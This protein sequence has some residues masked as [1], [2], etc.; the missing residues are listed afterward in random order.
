MIWMEFGIRIPTIR[1]LYIEKLEHH[2]AVFMLCEKN[3]F[4]LHFGLL[5]FPNLKYRSAVIYFATK[6]YTKRFYTMFSSISGFGNHLFGAIVLVVCFGL[7]STRIR[8]RFT[9]TKETFVIS[10]LLLI[11]GYQYYLLTK[12]ST[13][14]PSSKFYIYDVSS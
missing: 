4:P 13:Y 2:W 11:I 9:T 1:L 14:V 6:K 3:R 8:S 10:V 12:V 7:A 5:V